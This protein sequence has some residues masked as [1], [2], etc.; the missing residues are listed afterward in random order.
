MFRAAEHQ[1]NNRKHGRFHAKDRKFQSKCSPSQLL[2]PRHHHPLQPRLPIIAA[3]A[4]VK[5]GD[6]KATPPIAPLTPQP[7]LQ[8]E[9]DEIRRQPMPAL[10]EPRMILNA[11]PAWTAHHNHLMRRQVSQSQPPIP[12][13]LIRTHTLNH[14][15]C[16]ACSKGSVY[17]SAYSSGGTLAEKGL[18]PHGGSP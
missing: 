12:F 8:I 13:L 3:R 6:A 1:R 16:G 7:E 17:P 11:A 2:L 9:D 18:R 10:Q 5:D 4:G 14:P 15:F